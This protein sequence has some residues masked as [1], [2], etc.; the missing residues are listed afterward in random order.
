M[1]TEL[2]GRVSATGS[3]ITS[4]GGHEALSYLEIVDA[5]GKLHHLKAVVAPAQLASALEP[6]TEGTFSFVHAKGVHFAYAYEGAAGDRDAR[7]FV[8]RDLARARVKAWAVCFLCLVGAPL[9][10]PLIPAAWFGREALRI[11]PRQALR[12]AMA[13]TH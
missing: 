4:G 2:A 7:E 5:A 11:P 6:G 10:L 13:R 3:S 12:A 1:K 8:E 9:V